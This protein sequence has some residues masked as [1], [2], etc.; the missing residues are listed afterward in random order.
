MS[1]GRAYLD[2]SVCNRPLD[3]FGRSRR[4]D[5]F[6]TCDDDILKRYTESA[7]NAEN[8]IH[9]VMEEASPHDGDPYEQ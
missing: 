7:M 2:T 5:D 4:A 9:F 1:A 8:P 3:D 6:L